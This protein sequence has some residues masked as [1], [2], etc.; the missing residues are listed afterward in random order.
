MIDY[1]TTPGTPV[2]LTEKP[3]GCVSQHYPLTVGK[4]YLL[5]GFMGSCIVITTDKPD[6]DAS[7][8]R[9]RAVI[10]SPVPA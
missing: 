7:I 10:A 4:D 6:F 5:K 8:Y 1:K 2:R 3:D 9:G